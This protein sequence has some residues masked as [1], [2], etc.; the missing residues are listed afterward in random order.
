VTDQDAR[1]N[2]RL[3]DLASGKPLRRAVHCSRLWAINELSNDYRLEGMVPE[4][5]TTG[6]INTPLRQLAIRIATGDP[7]NEKANGM[8]VFT[9]DQLQALPCVSTTVLDAAGAQAHQERLAYD[10]LQQA[11]TVIVTSG[12]ALP[13][14]SKLIHIVGARANAMTEQLTQ[15]MALAD[16]SDDMLSILLPF[17]GL[18]IRD[19]QVWERADQVIRAVYNIDSMVAPLIKPLCN[20]VITCQSLIHADVL[21]LALKQYFQVNRSENND[22]TKGDEPV[23]TPDL[24]SDLEVQT[25]LKDPVDPKPTVSADIG[26]WYTI[27]RITQI[28]L[29]RKSVRV[30]CN[31]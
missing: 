15:A 27:N 21:R 8:V 11:R 26:D 3:Q 14:V 19:N 23:A 22:A 9:N 29:R 6:N 7:L 20:I 31:I 25:E 5:A 30:R 28:L 18:D 16:I 13:R 1:F 24:S 10:M 2:Y 12:G 17:P 4:L